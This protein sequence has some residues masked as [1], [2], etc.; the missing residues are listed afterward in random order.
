MAFDLP[1]EGSG[2]PPF[3]VER[4]WAAKTDLRL[5]LKVMNTPFYAK[6]V[7]Y[8]DIIL[9][10]P[11]DE[12][13]EIVFKKLVKES[14]HST[15]RL[16]FKA[17]EGRRRAEQLLVDHGCPWEVGT[18]D[19]IAVDVAPSIS[20]LNLRVELIKLKNEGLVGVQESAISTLH[21]AQL[22]EFP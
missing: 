4:V 21:Q 13:R 1:Q 19:Y 16:L 22:P 15:V 5:H 6:G 3:M 7:S 20:Y 11:D 18:E 2:W 10:R 12:R 8:G 17:A 14:G 9:V